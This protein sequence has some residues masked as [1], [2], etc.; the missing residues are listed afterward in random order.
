MTDMTKNTQLIGSK[1][2]VDTNIG[3]TLKVDKRTNFTL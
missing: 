3:W 2:T 1:G